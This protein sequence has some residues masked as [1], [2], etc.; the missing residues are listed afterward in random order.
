MLATV[1]RGNVP[2][3]GLAFQRGEAHPSLISDLVYS[4]P[5][6]FSCRIRLTFLQ[7]YII[8]GRLHRRQS[9]SENNVL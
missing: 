5:L 2:E 7:L 8:V 3:E 9:T 1:G 4:G 6:C